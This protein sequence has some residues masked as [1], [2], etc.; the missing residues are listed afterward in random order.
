MNNLYL[1]KNE[2][3]RLSKELKSLKFDLYISKE[4]SKKLTEVQNDIYKRFIFYKQYL[5]ER[6]KLKRWNIMY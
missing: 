5:E 4:D 6:G 2:L 3:C 1:K